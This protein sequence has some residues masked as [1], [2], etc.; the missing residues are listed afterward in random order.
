MEVLYSESQPKDYNMREKWGITMTRRNLNITNSC[1]NDITTLI[2]HGGIFH[3]DDVMATAILKLVYPDAELKR[4]FKVSEEE[5]N[6]SETLVY[7][8]GGGY[9]DHH[10]AD[11]ALREDGNK[12]AAVGIVFEQFQT[13]LFPSQKY[14]DS[15]RDRYIIPIEDADNGLSRN[16]LSSAISAFNCTFDITDPEEILAAFWDA[17]EFCT[18]I[19][20]REITRAR[21]KYAAEKEVEAAVEAAKETSGSGVIVTLDHYLPTDLFI[22]SGAMFVVSPSMRGGYQ[23]LTVKKEVGSLE[24]VLSLPEEWLT[25]KP[26]GCTFVHQARFIASFDTKENAEKAAKLA[27][28]SVV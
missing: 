14:A 10:Q 7:D 6:D 21:K 23:L 28:W 24:D 9:F 19:L 16:P 13:D 11:A 18:V 15:F 1:H 4:V 27:C 3:A 26:E 12:H 25:N 17:V 22:G 2:T 20:E 8:I 5:L